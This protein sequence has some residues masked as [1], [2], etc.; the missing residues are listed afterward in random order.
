MAKQLLPFTL[1]DI[2]IISYSI[3]HLN[4]IYRMFIRGDESVFEKYE[5]SVKTKDK[6]MKQITIANRVYYSK[7]S[8]MIMLVLLLY[9]NI[10]FR[11]A[12]VYTFVIY[13][14]E[15]MLFFPMNSYIILNIALSLSCLM[16]H[17]YLEYW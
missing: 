15:L 4:L 2:F 17:L 8:W 9:L 13:S 14:V 5:Q 6:K 10:P 12:M 1:F 3:V 7:A 16:E 11:S